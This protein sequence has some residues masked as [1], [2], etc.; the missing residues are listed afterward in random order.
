MYLDDDQVGKTM[1]RS[2]RFAEKAE[3]LADA[4]PET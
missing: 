2:R 1:K 3:S 4:K